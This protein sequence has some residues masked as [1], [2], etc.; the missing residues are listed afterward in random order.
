MLDPIFGSHYAQSAID[1]ALRASQ[2]VTPEKGVEPNLVE[3]IRLYS[4]AIED[5]ELAIKDLEKLG[6]Q[7]RDKDGMQEAMRHRHAIWIETVRALRQRGLPSAKAKKGRR[8]LNLGE[9]EGADRIPAGELARVERLIRENKHID[10]GELLHT[11]GVQYKLKVYEVFHLGQYL[12]KRSNKQRI[13]GSPF[14]VDESNCDDEYFYVDITGKGSVQVQVTEAGIRIN[15]Y[16]FL[17][18]D[19]PA[20]ELFVPNAKL[21]GV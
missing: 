21:A 16:P 11:L 3:A 1:L 14:V 8:L 15:V 7:V 5:A 18:Q 12:I 10:A 6:K 17:V 4:A 9:L 19:V 2:H 20:G 13:D